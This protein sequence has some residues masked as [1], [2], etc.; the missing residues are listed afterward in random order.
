MPGVLTRE[1]VVARTKIDNLSAV[2]NLNA[3]GNDI[4]D[5]QILNQ[6]PNVEVISLSVNRIS[7]LKDF[8]RCHKLQELYLRKN[9]VG[10]LNE[11]RHIANLPTLR[12]L[13]LNE[14]P[15]A[16][17]KNYRENVIKMLPCLMKLDDQ[18]I[19][20]DERRLANQIE[21]EAFGDIEGEQV[22]DIDYY[23]SPL[24]KQKQALFEQ[25]DR[26]EVPISALKQRKAQPWSNKKTAINT[27]KA[28][29]QEKYDKEN[30]QSQARAKL[31]TP[32]SSRNQ[33]SD[34]KD[35]GN[36]SPKKEYVVS[37]V[38]NL[39][40]VLDLSSL[41]FLKEDIEKRISKKMSP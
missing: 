11:L 9:N 6:L 8:A 2:R 3:W 13:W 4:E 33:D 19:T 20:N 35:S 15:C 1:L 30:V 10:N 21:L 5:V 29:A 38:M 32:P 24:E 18:P 14:N 12:V 22:A 41:E 37:A 40:E 31:V 25:V 34:E 26:N 27:P 16:G 17:A 28:Y 23:S 39:L 7:S 36:S